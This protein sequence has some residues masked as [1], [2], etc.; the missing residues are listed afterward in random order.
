MVVVNLY[1]FKETREALYEGAKKSMEALS[2]C[3]PYKMDMPIQGKLQYLDLKSRT[4][5]PKI[6][7]KETVIQ[8]ARE[9]TKF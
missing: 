3:K 2:L 8:D 7:T 1:P 4:K 6:I 5:K 9:I